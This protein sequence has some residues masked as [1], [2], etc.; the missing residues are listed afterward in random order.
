VKQS[1]TLEA[2]ID[3]PPKGSVALRKLLFCHP[4]VTAA[5][6]SALRLTWTNVEVKDNTIVW[7]GRLLS[8]INAV[9]TEYVFSDDGFR[10]AVIRDRQPTSADN[11]RLDY[12]SEGSFSGSLALWHTF[13]I[14]Q[15]GITSLHYSSVKDAWSWD[16]PGPI[17]TA[18][19]MAYSTV[20]DLL[21]AGDLRLWGRPGGVLQVGRYLPAECLPIEP[22]RPHFDKDAV[23]LSD[24]LMV[25]SCHLVPTGESEAPPKTGGRDT[26][27]GEAKARAWL[28]E[29]VATSPNKK[30]ITRIEFEAKRTEFGCSGRAMRR[31][32]D[33]AMVEN[34]LGSKAWQKPG[35]MN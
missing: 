16:N 30:T 21:R 15:E 17:H 31:A 14:D 5:A 35:P 29:M 27:A 19:C 7:Q 3:A 22:N 6:A 34:S 26:A 23:E 10:D 13:Y 9:D 11:E 8:G 28:K 4:S 12:V 20:L 24:G 32:W 25:F 2:S 33:M 1:S 18:W